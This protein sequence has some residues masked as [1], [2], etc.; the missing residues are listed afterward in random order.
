MK[1]G[2]ADLG[3]LRTSSRTFL[4]CVSIVFR[5]YVSIFFLP[6]EACEF[7][8]IGIEM[9]IE[10]GLGTAPRC[11]RIDLVAPVPPIGLGRAPRVDL[12][13]L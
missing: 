6:I 13:D 3:C 10:C 7:K 2:L 9:L 12:V 1:E 11:S 4:P 8:K 5:N